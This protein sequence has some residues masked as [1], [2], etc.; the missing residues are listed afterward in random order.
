VP[1][2]EVRRTVQLWRDMG[3]RDLDVAYERAGETRTPEDPYTDPELA[4]PLP[5]WTRTLMAFRAVPEDGEASA[6]RW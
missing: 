1:L 2:V 4:R 5:G 3:F 6:C